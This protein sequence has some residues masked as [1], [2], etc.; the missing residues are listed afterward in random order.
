[1]AACDPIPKTGPRP[2]DRRERAKPAR[3]CFGHLTALQILRA[4]RPGMLAPEKGAA[5]TLPDHAPRAEELQR[6]LELLETMHADLRFEKPAMFSSATRTAEHRR[7]ASRMCTA[8]P[9]RADRSCAW[10]ARRSSPRPQPVSF[11]WRD[12]RAK[13]RCSS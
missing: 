12:K 3:I 4:A 11:T 8:I 10:I 2:Y 6:K 13:R 1:M 5:R 7:L 9:C